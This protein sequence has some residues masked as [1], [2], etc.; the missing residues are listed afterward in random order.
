MSWWNLEDQICVEGNLARVICRCEDI[1][2]RKM[3][4]ES[5]H[6]VSKGLG[7]LIGSSLM[8]YASIGESASRI[9][10]AINATPPSTSKRR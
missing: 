9:Q 2:I 3:T 4:S 1:I 6:G 10:G 8:S 5:Q 7:S